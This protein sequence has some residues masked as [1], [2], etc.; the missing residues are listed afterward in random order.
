MPIDR[1][2]ALFLREVRLLLHK[3]SLI[4]LV[5]SQGAERS[6]LDGGRSTFGLWAVSKRT[7]SLSPSIPMRSDGRWE[8]S[9]GKK[10]NKASN[11]LPRHLEKL[12]PMVI[13]SQWKRH[14][15]PPC[16]QQEALTQQFCKDERR[17]AF[18]K[19]RFACFECNEVNKKSFIQ[20][21]SKVMKGVA[22][23]PFPG[24]D[25]VCHGKSGNA[26][27]FTTWMEE[28]TFPL[29]QE[30]GGGERLWSTRQTCFPDGERLERRS[31]PF[32]RAALSNLWLHIHIC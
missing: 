23:H 6:I 11:L 21:S 28:K 20:S 22:A 30:E 19:R 17:K 32:G 5:F 3:D 13:F 12:P 7:P 16:A 15:S 4:S 25:W 1:D 27:F 2:T 18:A 14:V 26:P 31:D 24:G 9:G 29:R 8:T 10:I